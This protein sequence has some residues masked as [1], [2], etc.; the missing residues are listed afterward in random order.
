MSAKG[1]VHSRYVLKFFLCAVVERMCN[2]TEKMLSR[3]ISY[4]AERGVVLWWAFHC[5][6]STLAALIVLGYPTAL[7]RSLLLQWYMAEYSW[8]SVWVN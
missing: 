1:F 3:L 6:P 5:N 7:F 8:L 4:N 2:R